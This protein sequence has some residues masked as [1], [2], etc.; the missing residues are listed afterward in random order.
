MLFAIPAFYA[1]G[2]L[3]VI[4]EPLLPS[5]RPLRSRNHL[6]RPLVRPSVFVPRYARRGSGHVRTCGSPAGNISSQAQ[7]LPLLL[8]IIACIIARVMF[9]MEHIQ[10][11]IVVYTVYCDKPNSPITA[12]LS[13]SPLTN[14][15][16]NVR[17]CRVSNRC[18]PSWFA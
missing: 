12:G 7:S 1:P 13:Y 8:C 2:T 3:F 6:P 15:L 9:H 18:F 14:S 4:P 16:I 11:C 17:F 10:F 5:S